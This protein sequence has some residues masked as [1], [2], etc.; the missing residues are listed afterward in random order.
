MQITPLFEKNLKILRDQQ[1][2]LAEVIENGRNNYEALAEVEIVKEKNGRWVKGLAKSPFFER[3]FLIKH[4][5]SYQKKSLFFLV[6]AGAPPFLFHQFR[7]LPKGTLA[8]VLFEPD[9]NVLI[10][11]LCSTSI[12]LALPV[13]CRLSIAHLPEK[14]YMQEVMNVNIRPMGAY[15]V[16]DGEFIIHEGEAEAFPTEFKK[17]RNS[18]AQEVRIHIDILGNSA[19]DTLLGFRQIA[20]NAL[21]LLWSPNLREI[22]TSFKGLPFI[23]VA[24]G[25]SLEKNI[26]LLKG[27]ENKCVIICAE[28]ALRRLLEEGILPHVVVTL[29]RPTHTYTN[30]FKV[31]VDN[32]GEQCRKILLVGQGVSPPQVF[33]RWPGP[34]IAVGKVEIPVDRWFIGGVLRGNILRSGMS[35]AH[36][37][38]MLASVWEAEKI[39]LIGQDLAFGEDGASHAGKTAASSALE[40]ERKRGL[41]DNLEIPGALGGTVKT[42]NI[43]FLFLKVFESMIP[44]SGRPVYDCTEGGALIKGTEIQPLQTFLNTIP[45]YTT[46]TST[47]ADETIKA[48]T[49]NLELK[50]TLTRIDQSLKQLSEC[51]LILDEMEKDV[52][53]AAGPAIST[54]RRRSIAYEL[55]EAMDNLNTLNPVL[56]FIGQSYANLSGADIAKSRWLETVEEIELWRK[57]HLEIIRAHRVN[58]QYLAQ[59]SLYIRTLVQILFD[60]KTWL[61]E[62]IE[63]LQRELQA[64]ESAN[65]FSSGLEK[66]SLLKEI[67]RSGREVASMNLL[68]AR[69]DGSLSPWMPEQQWQLAL[70]LHSQGRAEEA[71]HLMSYAAV[72]FEDQEMPREEILSFFKD[73]ARILITPDLCYLP[74]YRFAKLILDNARRYGEDDEELKEMTDRVLKDQQG[75]LDDL[76]DSGMIGNP[77]SLQARRITA[78]R[79]LNSGELP[80]TLRIIWSIVHD[81]SAAEAD[82]VRPLASWLVSTLTKCFYAEDRILSDTVQEILRLMADNPGTWSPLHLK[83]PQQFIDYLQQSGLQFSL[84]TADTE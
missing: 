81:F 83:L 77:A 68:A 62:S 38:L 71:S 61:N 8:V 41:D 52:H 60:G 14:E 74:Q 58:V 51:E 75:Y 31:L 12:Y 49:H 6:G 79:A 21:W 22:G 63:N 4:K 26:H 50:E 29:E 67:D 5:K 66:M 43:W 28:T 24:S 19:E 70:F 64:E 37:A 16:A 40:I 54:E 10:H 23:C 34:K 47:P 9:L 48:G 57:V 73:Y 55:S 36:M 11:T 17:L 15:V 69:S 27:K 30:Y 18:F 56:A 59:W 80:E 32:Y 33:G 53:R 46:L 1:P 76:Y 45:G 7:S 84:Q 78:E 3:N 42:T 25:P 39:A 35:V 72:K 44:E 13:G 2:L 82:S 20:L 65:L